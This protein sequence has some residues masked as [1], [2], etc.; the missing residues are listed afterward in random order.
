MALEWVAASRL[1]VA[2]V[3]AAAVAVLMP[4]LAM[5]SNCRGNGNSGCC[6]EGTITLFNPYGTGT[7]CGAPLGGGGGGR[8]LVACS[9]DAS[10]GR[11]TGNCLEGISIRC[12]CLGT[13]DLA[14]NLP[15]PLGGKP[16][17]GN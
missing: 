13:R 2:V 6:T 14:L 8:G 11:S 7:G 5:L 15:G 9:C 3:A 16:G 10:S 1:V 12:P 4:V 17:G